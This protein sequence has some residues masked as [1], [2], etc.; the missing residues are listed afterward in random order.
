MKVAPNSEQGTLFKENEDL[1][2]RMNKSIERKIVGKEQEIKDLDGLYKKKVE[3]AKNEGENEYMQS[4]DRNQ[5]RILGESNVFEE[6]IKGYEERLKKTHDTVALE[7]AALKGSQKD[8]IGILKT[9]LENNFQDQYAGLQEERREIQSSTQNAVKEIATKSKSEKIQMESNAQF[10]INALA[11]GFNQK[12]AD[13]EKDFRTKLDQDVRLHNS[14]VAQQKDELKK[15]MDTDIQ[16]NKRL[17]NESNRVAQDQLTYQSKH[18]EEILKQRDQDFKVRYERIVQDH[19]N[20]LKELSTHLEADVK[21]IVDKNSADKKIIE[22]RVA[23]PFYR[24]DKLM[25]KMVED[26]KSVVVS[27]PVADYEKENVHL[28]TQGRTIKI[29]LSRRYSDNLNDQDGSIN[30][31]TRSELYSKEFKTIDL[32]SPKDITQSYNDGILSFKIKKA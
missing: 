15:L 26:V 12:S 19:N 8:K 5:Q 10:E 11:S 6:K 7:E 17:S 4:L 13:S 31:S 20:V 9:E 28:S 32:L 16:K 24:V 29:T 2:K 27:V 25:P 18:Q 23:D 14:E 1:Y 22:D 30:R 21:K 3:Q